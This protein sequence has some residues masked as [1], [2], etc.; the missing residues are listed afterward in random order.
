MAV[1]LTSRPE[2]FSENQQQTSAKFDLM[3]S[4]AVTSDEL[5]VFD[6]PARVD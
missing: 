5:T 4:S 6:S 1:R 3:K 2:D